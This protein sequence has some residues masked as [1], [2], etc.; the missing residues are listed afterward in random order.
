MTFIEIKTNAL[1]LDAQ[2]QSKIKG[3]TSNVN[4]TTTTIGGVDIDAF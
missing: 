3:G 2:Q 4:T 1:I